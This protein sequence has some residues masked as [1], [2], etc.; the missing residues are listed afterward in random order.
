MNIDL[1]RAMRKLTTQEQRVFRALGQGEKP[2][3]IAGMLR[4]TEARVSQIRKKAQNRL[5]AELV[6]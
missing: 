1:E 2:K 3:R 5:R 4:I 6:A